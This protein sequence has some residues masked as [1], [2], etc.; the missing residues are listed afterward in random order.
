MRNNRRNR[1]KLI[2]II[3]EVLIEDQVNI[4]EEEEDIIC[5]RASDLISKTTQYIDSETLENKDLDTYYIFV[6]LEKNKTMG[7]FIESFQ[8]INS[9]YK[10]AYIVF[11]TNSMEES[12][13]LEI[14]IKELKLKNEI[15]KKIEGIH[16]VSDIRYEII[17]FNTKDIINFDISIES[18]IRSLENCKTMV[19][20]G[21]SLSIEGYVFT[22]SL[23]DIVN[24]YNQLGDELFTNNI[25]F[26]I[27][28]RLDVD[29]EIRKTMRDVPD[30]FWFLNNGITMIVNDNDFCLRRVNTIELTNGNK[31]SISVINGAQTITASAKYFFN[32]REKNKDKINEAKIKS[33]VLLRIIHIEGISSYTTQQNEIDKISLALNRQ[34]PIEPED[35]AYTTLFVYKINSLKDEN[36]NKFNFN[37]V[38]RGEFRVGGHTLVDFTRATKAYLAQSPGKARSTGKKTFLK[39]KT[40]DIGYEFQD[41]EIFKQEI[42]DDKNDLQ[43]TFNKY[44]KPVNFALEI[45]KYY[46]KKANSIKKKIELKKLKEDLKKK[47]IATVNYGKWYFVAYLIYSLNNCQNDD[48]SN[49]NYSI[50]DFIGTLESI[51]IEFI[52]CFVKS[53]DEKVKD[54]DSNDFKNESLYDDFKNSDH[55]KEFIGFLSSQVNNCINFEEIASTVE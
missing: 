43:E 19:L 42:L 52:S 34:K 39:I 44:Y 41:E 30:E 5:R 13:N 48:Y 27:D 8:L 15:K 55:S 54:I 18:R 14:E 6:M 32:H 17:L 23:F 2:S 1:E 33:K 7:E 25:R 38:R 50:N 35:I 26:G 12:I 21:E 22:A 20:N 24:I 40:T 29:T 51:I 10:N 47:E 16:S 45:N 53:I 9:G 31:K 46:S 36:N 4:S 3:K 28:D 37:L 11:L 49:F